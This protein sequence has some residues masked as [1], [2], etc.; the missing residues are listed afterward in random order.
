MGQLFHAYL[1]RGEFIWNVHMPS[2]PSWFWRQLLNL[3]ETFGPL[4]RFNIGLGSE[5]FF[6][7]DIWCGDNRLVEQCDDNAKEEAHMVGLGFNAKVSQII[8]NGDGIGVLLLIHN[9]WS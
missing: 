5:V 3:R 8:A 2:S 6:W 9:S 1:L 4:F 7:H